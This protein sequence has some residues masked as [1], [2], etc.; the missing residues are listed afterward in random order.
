M[1]AEYA[2]EGKIL[3][4][5]HLITSPIKEYE[6]KTLMIKGLFVDPDCGVKGVGSALMKE[7]EQ[8]AR[9][10]EKAAIL[11]LEAS[12]NAVEF[13]KKCGFTFL[14]LTTHRISEQVCLQCHKMI[15]KL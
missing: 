14:Q 2:E 11:I 6:Q 15:K 4:F 3:G 1:V 10:D 9:D 7:M 8:R 5:G 13:Y 12:L